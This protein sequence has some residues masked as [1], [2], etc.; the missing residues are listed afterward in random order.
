MI[1]VTVKMQQLL[2]YSCKSE[3]KVLKK[4]HQ[5]T[6]PLLTLKFEIFRYL[7]VFL[8]MWFCKKICQ[9]KI[10]TMIFFRSY[11]LWRSEE[12][13]LHCG[14]GQSTWRTISGFR[15]PVTG[16]VFV[17]T[18]FLGFRKRRRPAIAARFWNSGKKQI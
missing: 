8:T 13:W 10:L 7:L 1:I 11:I 2:S 12:D 14:L 18:R 9:I 16:S 5:V 3:N 4:E 17:G 6:T 15:F